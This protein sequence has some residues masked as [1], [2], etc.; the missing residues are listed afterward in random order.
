MRRRPGSKIHRWSRF[1][2]D[3]FFSWIVLRSFRHYIRAHC[4]TEM[5]DIEQAQQMI[6]LITCEISFGFYV[7]ELVFGVDALDLD[8]WVQVYSIEQQV[9]RNSVGPGNMYHCGT[10]SLNDHLDHR[11]SVLKHIQQSFL[12][13]KMDVWGTQSVWFKMLIIP[14]DRLLGPWSLSQFTT[15]CTFL[16][17]VGIVFPRT[18]TI[19]S[20][21]S[22]AGSPSN[23]NPASRRDDFGFCWTVWNWSLF[24][25]HPTYWNKCMTSKNA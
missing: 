5:A 23:L 17:W 10:P 20:H 11:F 15:G 6:P 25:A 2:C 14:W 3:S 1:C 12:M 19:R 18:E 7:S 22:R 16:S 13:R 9:K 4:R 21:K 8:F 24:V